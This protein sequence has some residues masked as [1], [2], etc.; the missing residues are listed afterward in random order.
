MNEPGDAIE[1]CGGDLENLV[2]C[3]LLAW[4]A[5]STPQPAILYWRTVSG[6]EV[7][8]VIESGRSLLPVEVTS[9]SSLGPQAARGIRRFLDDNPKRASAGLVLY[10]GDRA[11]WLSDRVLAT[12][13]WRVI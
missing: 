3:D 9:A 2:L 13:W 6:D 1:G 11:F 8:I 7:D 12:P 4:H 5:T 10:D